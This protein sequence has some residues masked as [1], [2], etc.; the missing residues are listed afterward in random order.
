MAP[1]A[2]EGLGALTLGE[3]QGHVSICFTRRGFA[4][5]LAQLER[6]LYDFA[7]LLRQLLD[8]IA[9]PYAREIVALF[10]ERFI[11]PPMRHE[12]YAR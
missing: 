9:R 4:A 7:A 2:G 6:D 11:R 1:R 10:E 8:E 3:P 5:A 12:R